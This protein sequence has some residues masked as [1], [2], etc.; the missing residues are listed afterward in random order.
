MG[1]ELGVEFSGF[2]MEPLELSLVLGV[3]SLDPFINDC[4]VAL[5]TFD[6]TLVR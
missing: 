6:R 2:S 4:P 5:N 3:Y 1:V